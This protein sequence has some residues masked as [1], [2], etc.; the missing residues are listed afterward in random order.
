MKKL[1][2]RGFT[3]AGILAALSAGLTV[4]PGCE[5]GGCS[6]NPSDNEVEDVYGP[7]PEPD[8]DGDNPDDGYGVEDNVPVTVYGPP[9]SFGDGDASDGTPIDGE[10][11][12]AEENMMQLMYG[13]MEVYD[14]DDAD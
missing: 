10:D 8:D 6:F 3:A 7:P 1:T 4:L 14:P 9:E 12:S 13:P 2:R 5:P 11:F